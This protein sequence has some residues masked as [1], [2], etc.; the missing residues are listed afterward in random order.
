M[1][2]KIR[3]ERAGD[4]P[5][6]RALN[7]AAFGRDEEGALVDRLREAGKLLVSLVAE[8]EGVVVGH[9]AFS[10]VTSRDAHGDGSGFPPGAGLAPM[11]VLPAFQRS[12]VGSRLVREGI[13]ACREAGVGYIVVLGHPDYYPRFGFVPAGLFGIGCKWPVPDEAFLVR[14]LVTGALDAVRGTVDYE[15]EFD[16]V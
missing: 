9:I 6:I 2:G 16:D 8:E 10:R 11:A 15:P 7:A 4:A 14:E 1:T 13:E 3:P 5:E 12:G